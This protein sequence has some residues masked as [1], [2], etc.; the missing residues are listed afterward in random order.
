[1]LIQR[2]IH[3]QRILGLGEIMSPSACRLAHIIDNLDRGGTQ[4]WFRH[5]T[6]GLA[7]RGYE[8]H[9]YCLNGTFNPEI[10]A[11][12]RRN[13]DLVEVIGRPR[14][15]AGIGVAGLWRDLRRLQPDLVFTIL[16]YGDLIGRTVAHAAGLRLIVSSEQSRYDDKWPCQF[17]LDR[18]TVRW[19][20][21]VICVAEEIIPYAIAHEGVRPDQAMAIPNGVE[22]PA[23]SDPGVRTSLRE[24][25]GIM[26][27]QALFGVAARLAH[28]KGIADLLT[29]YRRVLDRRPDTALWIIGDG[30]LRTS[31]ERQ[32]RSLR[33]DRHTTFLGD[34]N[35]IPDLLAAIDIFVHPS[36]SEG[37]PHSVMEA[38]AAGKPVIAAKVDG[39][40]SLIED[41]SNGWTVR[42]RQPD[43]LADRMLA[44]LNDRGAW[45]EVGAR[46]RETIRTRFSVEHMV[47]AYDDAFRGILLRP[48]SPA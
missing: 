30:P 5:L 1:M 23:A 40:A 39:V 17:W 31:L 47:A 44:V 7:E 12:I 36:L 16:P 29:A 6:A 22:I 41:G 4:T 2:H 27:N 38:M 26:P 20:E 48:S 13:A 45:L 37:M 28:Q 33:L 21:K 35:D 9:V 8:Q 24:R 32:A 42:P 46:A 19:V 43:E 11:D 3:I 34:R 15:F 10:L 25:F 14:L 18:I